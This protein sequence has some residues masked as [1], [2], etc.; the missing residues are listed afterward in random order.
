V[1]HYHPSSELNNF[2]IQLVKDD[3][4]IKSDVILSSKELAIERGQNDDEVRIQQT[5]DLPSILEFKCRCNMHF[6]KF[7]TSK[8]KTKIMSVLIVCQQTGSLLE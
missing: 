6:Q 5:D 7:S 3:H 8:F 1:T 4:Q 2:F